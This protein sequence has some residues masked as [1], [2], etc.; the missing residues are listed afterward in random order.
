MPGVDL[1][2]HST[3]SDGAHPPGDVV[4]EA[5]ALGLETIAL[6]DHDT[7]GGIPEATAAG[8]AA[9]VRVVIGCEFSVAV[10]W[11]EMHL[12]GYFLPPASP[13]LDPFLE[14]Q[15]AKRHARAVEIVQ[16]LNRAGVG[17]TMDD[18]LSAARNGAI[19]R[20][21]VARALMHRGVVRDIQTA[22]WKY[23]GQGRPAFVPKDLPPV[24][25]VAALVRSVGGLTAAAH[26][27]ERAVRSVLA[28]LKDA[29]VDG[30]EV[31]HPA[32]DDA[33]VRRID[34][35]AGA[36]GLLKTG[37]SD[38]HGSDGTAPDRAPLGS[39]EI[40]T[41]WLHALETAAAARTPAAS[42]S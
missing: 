21:H 18:V 2:M 26:L 20:P 16:R 5:A 7:L 29:G 1:H 35:L 9:G 10:G 25:T 13:L 34:R 30:V 3:A 23:L 40:P 27:R 37:G 42:D 19:G 14:D 36:L 31:R 12:L 6:T 41:A 8:A 22:F 24:A 4:R 32:H 15:R 39:L 38:W 28:D 17:I 33:T 11:G